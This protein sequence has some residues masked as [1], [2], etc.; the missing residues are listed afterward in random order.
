MRLV[1]RVLVL[2]MLM[3]VLASPRDSPRDSPLPVAA[4]VPVGPEGVVAARVPGGTQGA[5]AMAEAPGGMRRVVASPRAPRAEEVAAS[6]SHR[7]GRTGSPEVP[8]WRWPISGPARPAR[9]FDPP[10]QRW[11]AGHRGV[12]VAARP[13]EKVMAVGPGTVALAER[14]AGRG[15]VTISHPGGLRTTYLP[16]RALVRPGDV[17]VAGQVIGTIDEGG[18]EESAI[19]AGGAEG[20]G[21]EG[22]GGEEGGGAAH[23]AASCLHWGLLRGRLYLDPLL[24]FGRGQVRLLPQWLVG[25]ARRSPLQARGW[26][27]R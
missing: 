18:V 21:G 13:G 25:G 14:V 2:S 4:R 11:L 5:V 16:V 15:V 22:S 1:A 6:R 20:S 19:D 9:P 23:C 8:G 3:V 12:D 24:L 17:V 10:A 26:A 27:W 7:Q